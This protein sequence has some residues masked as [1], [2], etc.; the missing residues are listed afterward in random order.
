MRDDLGYLKPNAIAEPLINQWYAWSYLI[1]PA[2]AA[3]YIVHSHLEMM[4]SF[5]ETPEVHTSALKNSA[6][7]GGPFINYPASRAPDIQTL[8]EKTCAENAALI[9]LSHAID[10]LAQDLTKHP[11]GSSLESLYPLIPNALRGYVELVYDNSQQ[12][13]IRFLEGLLYRSAYY[14]PASQSMALHL[15]DCDRRSFVLS[16]PRLAQEG[17]VHLSVPFGDARVDRLF[18]MRH[19]PHLVGEMA[20]AFAIS[21]ADSKAFHHLFT[22]TPPRHSTPYDGDGVR[23]RYFGHACVLLE[24]RDVTLLCDPLISYDNPAGMPRYSYAD[25]PPSID[26]ALITHNHQDHVMLETLLQLRHKIK[27]V[28]VPTSQKGSLL[29]PSLQLALRQIG[30]ADVRA[31]DELDSIELPH[32]ALHSLPFLGEHGDLNIATKTAYWIHLKGRSI[33]CAAD[34]NNLEPQ[35]YH[36]L[37]HLFGKPD[38]LFL[39]MECEGAPFTWAYEPLLTQPVA[40]K[41]AQTRRLDGSNAERAKALVQQLRPQQVYVYAMGQEPWL[42][43]ITSINYSEDAVPIRESNQLIEYCKQQQIP[44]QRLLGQKNM[45]LT[46]QPVSSCAV[47]PIPVP[48]PEDTAPPSRSSAVARPAPPPPAPSADREAASSELTA[49][50]D[51][52]RQLQVRLWLDGDTLRCNAPKGVLTPELTAQLQAHKPDIVALLPGPAP[53]A[54]GQNDLVQDA[55][56]EPT[57]YPASQSSLSQVPERV[58][59]TGATGFLG[60]FLLYELLQQTTADIY[61]LVRAD[62]AEA[63]REKLE[64]GLASYQLC[65]Q[66]MRQ[67]TNAAKRIIPIIGDLAAPNLGL[68]TEPYDTLAEDIEV[69]YHNGARVHHTL[70]Y[71][72]LKP[73]NV[74]GTR[75]ILALACQGRPKPVHYTSTLSVL[76]LTPPSG[77]TKIYETDPLP[78][79][80]APRGGYNASKWVA[81]QLVTQAGARGLPVAI[82]RPGPISGH[83]QTGVFNPNDF[84]YRLVQGYIRLG[85]A[86]MGELEL[87]LLPVDYVSRALVA[88]S[89]KPDTIGKTFHFIHPEPISSEVLFEA[90]E[91]ANYPIRRVP[92]PAWYQQLIAIAQDDPEHPLYPLVPLFSS[93]RNSVKADTPAMPFDCQNTITALAA[94]SIVCPPLNRSLFD[95]YLAALRQTEAATGQP[96]QA[97][98]NDYDTWAWLYNR[99]MGPQYHQ[100]QWAYLERVLVPHLSPQAHIL[101][102]CCGTGQLI[103]PFIAAGYRVTGLDSSATMLNYARQNAPEG[104]Y[105][106]D[107]ARTF[108]LPDTFDAVFSTSAS[109]NHIMSLSDLTQVFRH[110]YQS[111]H[112]G[113]IFVFDL[114]HPAQMAKWWRGQVVEGELGWPYAW[115]LTPTYDPEA[116]E[117]AFHVT[118][119]MS[120]LPPP[121]RWW[122]PLKLMLYRVLAQPRFIGLRLRALAQLPRLEPEMQRIDLAYPVKGHDLQ[123]VQAALQQVGF[124]HVMVETID[125]S[126]RVD[127]NHSAH[128][129]CHKPAATAADTE[130]RAP[131]VV[132]H[133]L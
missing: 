128:F 8:L 112:P 93:R 74:E 83:S 25:L 34:S 38:I 26:Y 91:A 68:S 35:L 88:L 13:S 54:D 121:T 126:T 96:L 109:L 5:I 82:Y 111:L 41:L 20:E 30:F 92:Y 113:G 104:T 29:D 123:D 48:Q 110:V 40:H 59:L 131:V 118:M 45:E 127:D 4:K 100:G 72:E 33:V 47:D 94:T 24:S 22:D 85:S 102:L 14:N 39:G 28:V 86:P 106:L 78:D 37:Q 36:H 69:I 62:S 10:I 3:R 90:C 12:A 122:R 67:R 64:A 19:T 63:G 6:M 44:S 61:C 130:N 73:A 55:V 117:G 43:F 15:G 70:P 53:G 58:L 79:Y 46:P 108:D 115:M 32:G 23:I 120:P 65:D 56:L 80:P 76:P 87:D 105:V 133:V 129:I 97:E 11:S 71:A 31:L 107:D 49:F 57:I 101:D 9:N 84:L 89:L 27:Q 60:A 18:R 52:L 17:H 66:E 132:Q 125:G 116:A 21:A 124:T 119:Y 95:T 98:S 51:R 81:E 99:T 77:A 114:N 75:A 16:T 7:L 1:P 50:L 103:Q 42:T 2:P